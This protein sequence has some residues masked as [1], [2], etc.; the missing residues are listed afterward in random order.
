M[1]ERASSEGLAIAQAAEDGP[2]VSA[3]VRQLGNIALYKGRIEDARRLY[4]VAVEEAGEDELSVVRAQLNLGLAELMLGRLD[5]AERQFT[6]MLAIGERAHP[7]EVPYGRSA[8]AM[9]AVQR[10]DGAG[11]AGLI[12][13]AIEGFQARS[14]LYELAELVEMAGGASLLTGDSENGT[15][16][17]GASDSVYEAAGG[18]RP[19]GFF[20]DRYSNT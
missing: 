2:R 19:D 1:A 11:A 7:G 9:V 3:F 8:L 6:E 15:R 16:L 4:G 17:L 18:V 10:G 20:A 14:N 12:A 5:A 13:D